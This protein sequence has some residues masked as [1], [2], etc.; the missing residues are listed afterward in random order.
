MPSPV[1]ADTGTIESNG[2]LFEVSDTQKIFGT[3]YVHSGVV[4]KGTLKPG[5]NFILKIDINKTNKDIYRI[6]KLK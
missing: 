3:F 4:K 2:V 6:S 1:L 5:D